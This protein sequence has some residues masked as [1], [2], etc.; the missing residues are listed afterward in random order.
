MATSAFGKIKVEIDNLRQEIKE[1]KKEKEIYINK[2]KLL[3]HRHLHNVMNY[4]ISV[5]KMKDK[6]Y[7]ALERI[8]INAY[9]ERYKYLEVDE[10]LIVYS[11]CKKMSNKYKRIR[12]LNESINDMYKEHDIN[13]RIMI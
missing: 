9:L 5:R 2:N 6:K 12:E 3:K 8:A 4:D 11:L 7:T 1:L 10:V 13:H